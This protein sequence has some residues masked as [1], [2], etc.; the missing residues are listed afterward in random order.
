VFSGGALAVLSP[1]YIS[2]LFTEPQ[3][4]Q[5]LIIALISLSTGIGTMRTIISR[6]LS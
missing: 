6:S 1:A 3:G 4:Q 2:T 5:V